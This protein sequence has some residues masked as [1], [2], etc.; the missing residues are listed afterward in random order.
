MK[1]KSTQKHL[2]SREIDNVPKT[3]TKPPNTQSAQKHLHTRKLD[4]VPKTFSWP[5]TRQG[6]QKHLKSR[7]LER[8]PKDLN[9]CELDR[10]PKNIHIAAN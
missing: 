9:S 6:V 2:H 4:K 7:D 10:F 5:R 8:C 1:K 3:S